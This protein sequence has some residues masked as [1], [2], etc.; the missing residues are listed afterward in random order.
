MRA[1]KATFLVSAPG[2]AGFPPPGAPEI[3]F[4]GRSNVG[5]SSLINTLTDVPKLAKTSSTPGRTQLLNWFSIVAPNGTPL[6]F[7]DLP[8]YGYAK[9][10]VALRKQWQ[11]MVETYVE[12]RA[13]LRL[14]VVLIDA[15]RGAEREELELLEWLD[16]INKP[17]QVVLTKADKIVKSK[18]VPVAAATRRE[19]GLA[20]DPITFS[21]ETA[22]G[23]DPLWKAILHS[24]QS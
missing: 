2:P 5:K 22:D 19:L 17:A 12:Q 1:R 14:V 15:R 21:A 3:A 23:V 18:R 20:R 4:A 10:P 24:V 9:V 13:P 11:P 16:H 6:S 8:G 7:V